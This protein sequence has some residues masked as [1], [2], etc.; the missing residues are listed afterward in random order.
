MPERM[1]H[2]QATNFLLVAHHTECCDVAGTALFSGATRNE[3]AEAD[4]DP[5]LNAGRLDAGSE[6][7]A[8]GKA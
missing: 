3:T 8:A 5:V 2:F 1:L 6:V 7:S 4:S